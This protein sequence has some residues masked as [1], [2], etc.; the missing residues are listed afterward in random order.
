MI[1]AK[2]TA[3]FGVISML[4]ISS[5]YQTR[6]YLEA[7]EQPPEPDAVVPQIS[8]MFATAELEEARALRTVCPGG[9]SQMEVQ[10]TAADGAFHYLTLGMYS[11]QSVRV[12]CQRPR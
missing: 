2:R 8:T 5:C 6:L 9:V 7:S 10:Q 11:P 12:W 4:G 1:N 3:I